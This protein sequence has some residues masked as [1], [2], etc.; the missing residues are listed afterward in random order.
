M[1]T[2]DPCLLEPLELP[3]P[4]LELWPAVTAPSLAPPPDSE[5]PL[6][7]TGL[8]FSLSLGDPSPLATSSFVGVCALLY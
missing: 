8:A 4:I 2:S 3:L 5:A 6:K 7:S 1:G